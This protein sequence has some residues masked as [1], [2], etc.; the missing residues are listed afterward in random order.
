MECGTATE[1][2]IGPS[3]AYPQIRSGDSPLT[4]DCN[5]FAETAGWKRGSRVERFDSDEGHAKA[6]RKKRRL[7]AWG[8]PEQS[9][10]LDYKISGGTFRIVSAM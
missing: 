1:C 5:H 7:S 2:R 9:D 6:R 8:V 10:P 4:F 3:L